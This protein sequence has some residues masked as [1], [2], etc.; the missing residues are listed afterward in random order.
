[1]PTPIKQNNVVDE[2]FKI[3][4]E[5]GIA[6][7]FLGIKQRLLYVDLSNGVRLAAYGTSRMNLMMKSLDRV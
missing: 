6:T 5:E 2:L 1:M 4:E 3:T 7:L